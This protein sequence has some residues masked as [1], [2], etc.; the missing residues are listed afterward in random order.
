MPTKSDAQGAGIQAVGVSVGI[1]VFEQTEQQ[2]LNKPEELTSE[3]YELMKQHVTHSVAILQEAGNTNRAVI[4]IVSSHHER[5]NGSGYLRGV[6]Q[7]QIPV[8]GQ[9]AAIVDCY[10]AMVS[11]KIYSPAVSPSEAIRRL[12]GWADDLFQREL[13]EAFIQA[14]GIYAVGSFVELSTGEIA[15]VVGQ[16]QLRRLRPK[17]V[18]VLDKDKKPVTAMP[19]ID[20]MHELT[21][22]K[23]EKLGIRRSIDPKD[24]D[25]DTREFYI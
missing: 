21:D 9:I 11:D 20:L 13:V 12:Y 7:S 8:L 23:G 6:K 5:F 19:I 10:D 15:I 2:I 25:I 22:H 14:I 1:L 18:V 24:Y 17:V 16:N 3:E 4:E